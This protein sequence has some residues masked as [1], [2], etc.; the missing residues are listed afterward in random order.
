MPACHSHLLKRTTVSPCMTD[1]RENEGIMSIVLC[2]YLMRSQSG[3]VKRIKLITTWYSD[4]RTRCRLAAIPLDID[5]T[6]SSLL[7]LWGIHKKRRKGIHGQEQ[8]C[9]GTTDEEDFLP[10]IISKEN[11]SKKH[12]IMLSSKRGV[13]VLTRSTSRSASHRARA[14]KMIDNATSKTI[15]IIPPSD[16]ATPP[17]LSNATLISQPQAPR[18]GDFIS[19]SSSSSVKDDEKRKL[20][21]TRLDAQPHNAFIMSLFR[22]KMVAALGRDV[23]E[24]GYNGIIS[25]TRQLNNKPPLETQNK[26]IAIL[27]SL[28]PPFLPGLFTLFFSRPFPEFSW[29]LNALATALA[30]QWLMGPCKVNDA[31]VD[32]SGM[33]KANGVKVER[34]RYLEEAGC[35]SICI[36]SCKVPTQAFFA[37]DMGLSLEMTPNYEDFSCQFSFGKTSK[38]QAEDPAFQTSCYS[39]C[40]SRNPMANSECGATCSKIQIFESL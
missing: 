38:A 37:Q 4:S 14:A 15:P 16:R 39:K 40:P 9:Q 35:A 2:P 23:P 32:G 33:G 3:Y 12:R 24:A 7:K 6:I 27:R 31:E 13:K 36:N 20:E 30:C 26:T 21:Y 25:L 8:T 22:R 19:P 1:R 11:E 28:F 5:I 17:N 10:L 34:C 29:R 18:I